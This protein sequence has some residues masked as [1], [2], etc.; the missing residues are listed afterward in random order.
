M[1]GGRAGG[2]GAP[3]AAQMIAQGDKDGDQKLSRAEM[4]GIADA[5][6]EKLDADHTGRVAQQ[7]FVARFAAPWKAR[8][9][10]GRQS[11][12]PE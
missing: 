3:L 5:W 4:A 2:P 7:D 6:F 10:S 9:N 1:G 12:Y 8:M 11:G